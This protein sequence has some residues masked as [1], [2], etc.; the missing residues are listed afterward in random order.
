MATEFDLSSQKAS[1]DAE[2][3]V[4]VIWKSGQPTLQHF[5]ATMKSRRI[6]PQP[7]ESYDKIRGFFR[8]C[9]ILTGLNR[10]HADED[11]NLRRCREPTRQRTSRVRPWDPREEDR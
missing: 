6:G 9:Q 2:E 3:T 4:P 8:S 1:F 7:A 10:T 5:S 11:E